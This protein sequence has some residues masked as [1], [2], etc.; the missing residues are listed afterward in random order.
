MTPTRYPNNTDQVPLTMVQK[1]RLLF[2]CLPLLF[3]SMALLF[4]LTPLGDIIGR[5]PP[6]Y[7]P[8]F[9]GLVILVMGWTAI[10][11]VRDVLSGVALV[12]EDLL[13][14]SWRSGHNRGSGHFYGQFAQL[15]KL[16]LTSKDSIQSMNGQR[17]RVVYSPVSRIVWS[18]E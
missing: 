1:A 11:R 16:R 4:T 12:R 2:D 6:V 14:R 5:T 13:Q 9:L 3:F 17:Y 15:G 8:L 18:L 10:Q 7:L